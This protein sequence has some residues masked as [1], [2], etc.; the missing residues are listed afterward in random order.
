VIT[1]LPRRGLGATNGARLLGE[2]VATCVLLIDFLSGLKMRLMGVA[3]EGELNGLLATLHRIR[4]WKQ[5]QLLFLAIPPL[6]SS[7]P[8][9]SPIAP[10]RISH[11][12]TPPTPLAV[13]RPLAA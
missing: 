1:Q 8:E 13:A 12:S 11:R 2:V 6:S 3:N 9:T 4:Q 10:W 7:A 5:R